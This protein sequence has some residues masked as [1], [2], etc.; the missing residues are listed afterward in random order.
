MA[1]LSEVA[2]R[3]AKVEAE[4]RTALRNEHQRLVDELKDR[5]HEL[6]LTQDE[7]AAAIGV[8]RGQI[9]N[10]ESGPYLLSVETLIGYAIAVGSRLVVNDGTSRS[11]AP[12]M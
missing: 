5:R 6:G 8:S 10:A 12:E 4:W 1:D 11:P 9:A 7:V 3:R 2:N